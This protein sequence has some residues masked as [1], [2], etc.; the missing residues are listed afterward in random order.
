[1]RPPNKHKR[2]K[3]ED[4]SD[5]YGSQ[6]GNYWS[7]P[8]PTEALYSSWPSSESSQPGF[9]PPMA[10][11]MQTTPYFSMVGADQ[12][13]IVVQPDQGIQNLQP[14]HPMTPM[15]VVLLPSYPMCPGDNGMYLQGT[16]M[17]VPAP[18]VVPQP[19]FN[20][21]GYISP[22]GH[23]P[24]GS[25]SQGHPPGPTVTGVGIAQG[26]SAEVDSIPTPWFGEDL[27]AAQPTALFS[28]SRSSSP[29][30]LNLLQEELTK[31]TEALNSTG[32][33]ILLKHHAKEVRPTDRSDLINSLW[34]YFKY[35]CNYYACIVYDL[36]FKFF[37]K[38]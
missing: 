24:H 22:G 23:V 16:R 7:L 34:S 37:I 36:I 25:P 21:S 33:E 17:P 8:G 1:M 20:M 32:P 38:C 28:S 19:P 35:V 4:S 27:D 18:G 5:S 26:A 3:P 14:M 9:V 13:P 6:P 10:V 11:P 29:I 2:P 12:Q 30:Q 15:M 31:P